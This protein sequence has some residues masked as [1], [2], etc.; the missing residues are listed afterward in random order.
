MGY[1]IQ[2]IGLFPHMTIEKNISLLPRL[3]GWDAAKTDN[4]IDELLTLVQ[5]DPKQYRKRYPRQLS[6]GQQQRIGIARAMVTDPEV[7]L[8]DEPF[9]AIDEITRHELQV[10]L[11]NIY[12]KLK[13]TILF[14][15]HDVKE[16]L[17]MG[18]RVLI[19]STGELQQFDTPSNILLSP[20]NEFVEKLVDTKNVMRQLEI[21]HISAFTLPYQNEE[22][23]QTLNADSELFEAIEPIM[24]NRGK[25][26]AVCNADGKPV[27]LLNIE[28][29]KKIVM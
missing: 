22:Y 10:E 17:K 14:V 16:A 8:M 20:A 25:N 26:I 9:G 28:A 19:M 24:D 2:Q 12:S 27:G 11:L 5:L 7:L 13:K 3:L 6:G 18:T 23:E 15:T 1:V 21:Q 29:I 4:R